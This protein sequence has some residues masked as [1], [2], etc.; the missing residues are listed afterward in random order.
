VR[1]QRDG[2]RVSKSTGTLYWGAGPLAE[3]D[4]NGSAASWKDYVFFGG[5][6]VARR[7]AADGT[8]HFFFT[9]HLGSTS[10][11]T[12]SSGGREEDIDY[13]PYGSI[14][15]GSSADHYLF[16]GKERDSETGLDYFGARYYHNNMG[17][18]M[19][20]DWAAAPAA[21]PYVHFEDP[22]TLNLYGYLR[23]NPLLKPDLDGHGCPPDCDPT[24]GMKDAVYG[25]LNGN[26]LKSAGNKIAG[27]WN[28]FWGSHGVN[29]TP[30]VTGGAGITQ[31]SSSGEKSY[32]TPSEPSVSVE[33]TISKAGAPPTTYA[34]GGSAAHV[35]ATVTNQPSLTVGATT[36]TTP[37]FS[38][39]V[40][41]DV[42][43]NT[44]ANTL[45][46]LFGGIKGYFSAPP[47]PPPPPQP[48][49]WQQ[50]NSNWGFNKQ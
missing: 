30:S 27:A 36:D 16:N 32:Q 9:N 42:A 47:P 6:R 18:W 48:P 22:Q 17:K 24:M 43:E 28:N 33:V 44:I 40:P 13:T 2:N 46:T 1:H 5:K 8:I 3:S 26:A 39:S 49:T 25:I 11:V 19:T 34:V 20:P 50:Q 31:L 15:Y 4:A 23:N 37:S 38:A 14:A 10:I 41:A 12:N 35:T 45:S 21:V 29:V 7:D